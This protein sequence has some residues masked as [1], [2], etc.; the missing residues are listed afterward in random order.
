MFEYINIS[1]TYLM[2]EKRREEIENS[3]FCLFKSN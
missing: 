2:R 3:K 1:Y